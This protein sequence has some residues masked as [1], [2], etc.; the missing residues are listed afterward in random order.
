MKPWKLR[1]GEMSHAIWYTQNFK[2]SQRH[3]CEYI[4][5]I[6]AIVKC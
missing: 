2:K 1:H 4:N 3:E 5:E 6:L